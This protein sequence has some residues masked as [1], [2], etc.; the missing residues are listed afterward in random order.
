MSIARRIEEPL[1]LLPPSP[2]AAETFETIARL[3]EEI[4]QES[5]IVS[6]ERPDFASDPAGWRRW[7]DVHV[8][9]AGETPSARCYLPREAGSDRCAAH[10][11]DAE[12]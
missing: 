9:C 3:Q 11:K 7:A 12:R 8:A 1:E 6:L 5:L 10:A 2:A 4:V